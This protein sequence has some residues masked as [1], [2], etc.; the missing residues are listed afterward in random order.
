MRGPSDGPGVHRIEFD[1]PWPPGA[2]CAYLL[3]AEEPILVDAGG[4]DDSGWSALQ[5]GL[6]TCRE[7]LAEFGEATPYEL[8]DARID[9]PRRMDFSL[10][11]SLGALA[12]L[13]R[14]GA[15]RSE[16]VGD[17]RVSLDA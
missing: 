10:F 1:V 6:D 9:D 4:P 7:T 15:V 14:Q 8:T 13:K 12:R 2:A 17:V 11:E 16:F 3:A 5:S